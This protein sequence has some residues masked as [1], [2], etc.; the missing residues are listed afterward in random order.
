MPN[1]YNGNRDTPAPYPLDTIYLYL[2]LPALFAIGW[3]LWRRSW[4]PYVQPLM[5]AAVCL[6]VATNPGDF[7]YQAISRIPLLER[8]VQS[9]NFYE[10]VA[11]MAAL[12]TALA[13]DDFLRSKRAA[14]GQG[15][16][17]W[18][19]AVAAAAL[20]GWAMRQLWIS[21]RGGHF[22]VGRGSLLETAIA[23]ALF[24]GGMWLLRAESGSRRAILA[25]SLLLAVFADYKAFGSNRDFNTRDGDVDV[26]HQGI[27]IH[28]MNLTAYWALWN[29][30]QFRVASDENGGPFSTDYRMWGL[31]TP[32]GLDPFLPQ[33][34]RDFIEQWVPWDSN[35]EFRMDFRNEQMLQTL[36]VRFV[37]THEGAANAAWLRA[38]PAFRLIGRDDSFYRVY[39]YLR[40]KPPYGWVDG[41]GSSR[42]I[43]WQ[44]ERRVFRA[45]SERGGGFFLGEELLPGWTA[46]IDGKTVPVERWNRVFQAIAVPPGAHTLIFEYHERGLLPGVAVGLTA[47]AALIVAAKSRPCG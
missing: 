23:L 37:I 3:M 26:L 16:A 14:S 6:A 38:N 39:D 31:A 7:V 2:G 17:R 8:T 41:A 15:S 22:A 28:G 4:R 13:L 35:R 44:P 1:W 42:P 36:G 27:G 40:A 19:M 46:S 34:Y 18:L 29:N 25:A 5:V 12:I 45:N 30:R 32:L 33:A 20:T 47:M 10:G 21:A 9:Y 11:A 24:S 43:G